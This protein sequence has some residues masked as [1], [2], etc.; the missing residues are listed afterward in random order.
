MIID[1]QESILTLR[2]LRYRGRDHKSSPN[3]NNICR[4]YYI[5]RR[6]LISPL[7]GFRPSVGFWL[8]IASYLVTALKITCLSLLRHCMYF[9]RPIITTSVSPSCKLMRLIILLTFSLLH[10]SMSLRAIDKTEIS[11]LPSLP[12]FDGNDLTPKRA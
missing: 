9:K 12:I 2:Q 8:E 11:A 1:S 3:D 5:Y 10:P 4:L 7:T 6:Y